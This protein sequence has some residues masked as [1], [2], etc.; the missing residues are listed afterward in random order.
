MMGAWPGAGLNIHHR[1][2]R[3]FIAFF[4]C[5]LLLSKQN[6]SRVQHFYC[7]YVH[8]TKDKRLFFVPNFT[9][10][11][12]VSIA[13]PHGLPEKTATVLHGFLEM[14]IVF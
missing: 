9:W 2:E 6:I 8:N 7:V 1:M 13:G 12:V 10:V 4:S 11:L 14:D 3:L 5:V